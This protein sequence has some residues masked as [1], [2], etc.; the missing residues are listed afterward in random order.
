M[1]ND[2]SGVAPESDF[3]ETNITPRASWLPLQPRT[4]INVATLLVVIAVLAASAPWWTNAALGVWQQVFPPPPYTG[5]LL[6]ED[7]GLTLT[8]RATTDGRVIWQARS[9]QPNSAF[10]RDGSVLYVIPTGQQKVIALRI[11]DGHQLWERPIPPA[12]D[13][14]FV[15]SDADTIYLTTGVNGG[16]NIS[17][18]SFAKLTGRPGIVIS[19]LAAVSLGTPLDLPAYCEDVGNE[20]RVTLMSTVAQQPLWQRVLPGSCLGM[21]MRSGLVVD[22][23]SLPGQQTVHFTALNRQAGAT[24]WQA[25]TMASRMSFSSATMIAEAH[26]IEDPT[27]LD[28]FTAI[29]MIS[30]KQLWSQTRTGTNTSVFAFSPHPGLGTTILSTNTNGTSMLVALDERSGATRWTFPTLAHADDPRTWLADTDMTTLYYAD[31]SQLRAIDLA[32]GKHRWQIAESAGVP[33]S[34]VLQGQILYET[35]G[36]HLIARDAQTGKT[37]WR[38]SVSEF[39]QICGSCV[40]T[41]IS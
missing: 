36:T 10:L 32:T 21:I 23:T 34:L 24:L 38:R 4:L 35:D 12:V 3:S 29:D 39:T 2:Q 20:H 6:F 7:N 13:V 5:S 26:P 1:F 16:G 30:G 18:F 41:T 22:F 37:R 14:S 25:D 9:I 17:L 33:T 15:G 27:A 11:S 19:N 31:G 40:A 28:S 8:A